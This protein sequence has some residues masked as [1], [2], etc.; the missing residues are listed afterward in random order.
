[1]KI[2]AGVAVALAI[3]G[4]AG[5][6]IEYNTATALTAQLARMTTEAQKLRGQLTAA[7]IDAKEAHAQAAGLEEKVKVTE[8]KSTELEQQVQVSEE[9]SVENEQQLQM[10]AARLVQEA[11]A[12]LPIKISFR[13]S[14]LGN[15]QVAVLHNVSNHE[16]E[17][18][19]DVQ[20]PATGLRFHQALVIDANRIRQI[21]KPEGW[22]FAPGQQVKLNNPQYRP[23]A[24]T[25][26]G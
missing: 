23:V 7:T 12:D 24:G 16:I 8:A 25:V 11:R 1:M 26:G 4:G 21:G 13:K 6:L 3:A 10:T 20:S 19:L 18:T 22:E 14:L 9:K 17:F 5:T 15:G 2:V